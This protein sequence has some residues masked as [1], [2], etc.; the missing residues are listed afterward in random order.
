MKPYGVRL[1]EWPD[2]G[3]IQATGR[4]SH[5]GRLRG[6]SGDFHAYQRSENRQR[7]RRYW[8]RQARRENKREV[9]NALLELE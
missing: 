7:T 6:K 3:D 2:V 5:V 4:A 8:K 9:V 1:I